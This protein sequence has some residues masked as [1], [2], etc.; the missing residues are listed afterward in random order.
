MT[1][2]RNDRGG[3]P[4]FTLRISHGGETKEIG[5]FR[6]ERALREEA[7]A[8]KRQGFDVRMLR[9]DTRSR[10]DDSGRDDDFEDRPR[11][12]SRRDDDRVDAIDEL[13]R[14]EP[15]KRDR[16]PRDTHPWFKDL[17]GR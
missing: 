12:R 10:G 16:E 6:S 11:G 7:E 15:R 2:R 8:Y 14:D 5:P 17:L 13:D 4:A 3:I 9:G 1:S